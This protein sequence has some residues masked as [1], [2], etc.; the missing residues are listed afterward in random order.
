[1]SKNTFVERQLRRDVSRRAFLGGAAGLMSAGGLWYPRTAHAAGVERKFLFCYA[2]GGWD[3]TTILDPHYGSDG[4]A[5][6][7]GVDMDPMTM[8]GT[9]GRLQYTSGPDRLAVDEYMSNWGY[10]TAIINGIEDLPRVLGLLGAS[11][12]TG[13]ELCPR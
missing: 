5:P 2:G 7:S 3:T 12:S 4:M 13:G 6:V 1:M 10:R 9:S 8:L 11:E